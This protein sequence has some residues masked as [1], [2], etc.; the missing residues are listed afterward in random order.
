MIVILLILSKIVSM[1]ELLQNLRIVINPKIFVKDPQSSDLGKRIVEDGIQLISEIGFERFTFRKL[2]QRIG[3][4]ESSIYRYFENK[5]KFLIYLN[6]WYWGWLEYR[7]VLMTNS[8][9]DPQEKLEKAL[10]VLTQ[11]VEADPAFAHVDEVALNRIVVN[12]HFKPFLTPEVD[13]ENKEGYFEVYKRLVGR[14]GQMIR[15]CSPEYPYALSLASMVLSGSLHQYFLSAHFPSL[16]DC[17][18]P[19]AHATFFQMLVFS[20]LSTSAHD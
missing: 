13:Q 15:D 3:S 14:F 20:N 8:I 12:E 16:T 2:G 5:H 7:L 1:T 19:Q 17:S 6:S 9:S 4:N 10:E 18:D 11:T